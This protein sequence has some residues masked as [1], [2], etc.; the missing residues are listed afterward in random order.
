MSAAR[1]RAPRRDAQR[2]RARIIDV[3]EQAFAAEGLDVP[4]DSVAKRAGVGA[5]T[6][7]RHFPTREDLVAAVLEGRQPDL[8]RERA[9]IE[10]ERLEPD[11]ALD[12]WLAVLVSWMRAYNGLPGSLRAAVDARSTP[13]GMTCETV[14]AVTDHFLGAAQRAGA[15][16]PD[17]QGLDLFLGA[18]GTAWA[19]TASSPGTEPPDGRTGDDLLRLLRCGWA[20]GRPG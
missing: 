5:G 2:N 15:A 10:A 17:V 9:G 12:R 1:T 18:L 13:L 16:R 7:Y 20:V 4:L 6:L 11:A 14:I 3:A 8:D 19:S